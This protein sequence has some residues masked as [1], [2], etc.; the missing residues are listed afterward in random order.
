MDHVKDAKL[1]V[2][3]HTDNTGDRANNMELSK[4]R[5]NFARDYLIR[6][7]GISTTRMDVDG[8]GPDKP[9]ATNKTDEGKAQNRRVEV[10]LK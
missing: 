10:T 2:E 6:N 1:D 5:A 3:G 4:D 9:I 7:G 8:F